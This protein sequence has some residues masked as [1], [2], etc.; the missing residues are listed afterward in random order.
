M[1]ARECAPMTWEGVVLGWRGGREWGHK[2]AKAGSASLFKSS[3][4]DENVR[5][6]IHLVAP[7]WFMEWD[8][9]W[10][11]KRESGLLSPPSLNPTTH[12]H[13]PMSQA[14]CTQRAADWALWALLNFST[15]GRC[16]ALSCPP[17]S[18]TP[19]RLPC[20]APSLH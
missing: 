9:D 5:L 11:T 18:I 3:G 1:R 13:R 12:T 2:K 6:I 10:L 14:A 20:R 17:L 4:R 15:K 16:L 7:L 8:R 19:L